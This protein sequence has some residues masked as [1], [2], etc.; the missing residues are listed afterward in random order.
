[1]SDQFSFISARWPRAKEPKRSEMLGM[2]NSIIQ[3]DDIESKLRPHYQSD[4]RKTGRKGY[5]LKMLI[6]CYIV[7]LMWRLSDESLENLILDSLAVAK[8]IGTDPWDPRPPSASSFRN[9]RHLVKSSIGSGEVMLQVT[10]HL[11]DAKIQFRQGAMIDPVFRRISSL[12]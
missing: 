7:A 9:F 6:R 3:W 10:L 5:S 4:I 1:M 11:L 8:F 2:L 12:P